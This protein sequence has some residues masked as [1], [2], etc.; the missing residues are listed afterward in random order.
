MMVMILLETFIIIY[1]FLL[2]LTYY[3][4]DKR[5]YLNLK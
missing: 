3:T 1:N 5:R 2:M 4:R